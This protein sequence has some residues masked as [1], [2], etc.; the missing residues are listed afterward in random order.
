MVSFL[1][2]VTSQ[3]WPTTYTENED[4]EREGEIGQH[5]APFPFVN[6]PAVESDGRMCIHQEVKQKQLSLLCVEFPSFWKE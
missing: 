2:H 4:I 3:Y 6:K 1:T 5:T